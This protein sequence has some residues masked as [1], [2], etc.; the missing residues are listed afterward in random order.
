M[1][2]NAYRKRLYLALNVGVF[3]D[4]PIIIFEQKGCEA[5]RESFNL[6]EK[7]VIYGYEYYEHSPP[8]T[9][10]HHRLPERAAA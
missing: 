4:N 2:F 9:V 5:T 8:S 6:N 1:L 3:H 10:H 7:H